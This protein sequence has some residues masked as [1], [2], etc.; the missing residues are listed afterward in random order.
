M[1]LNR[2][3]AAVV[4]MAVVGMLA[5]TMMSSQSR[6]VE[7]VRLQLLREETRSR[8]LEKELKRT[9]EELEAATDSL[10]GRPPLFFFFFFFFFFC[11]FLVAKI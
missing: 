1:Q 4:A 6:D 5:T 11:W 9:V 7:S 10:Y 3:V 2:V 8:A